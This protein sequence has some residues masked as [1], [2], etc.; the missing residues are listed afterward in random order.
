M[1]LLDTITLCCDAI[2]LLNTVALYRCCRA[3]LQVGGT[4]EPCAVHP[5]GRICVCLSMW[6]SVEII[7]A[8][9]PPPSS[10]CESLLSRYLP[11]G[12]VPAAASSPAPAV[13]T[14]CLMIWSPGEIT[15]LRAG[16]ECDGHT[17]GCGVQN[18]RVQ[19]LLVHRAIG[20]SEPLR[21][22]H[23]APLGKGVAAARE[24]RSEEK[25]EIGQLGAQDSIV[26]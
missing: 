25:E 19:E 9:P 23:M 2:L 11:L 22:L 24:Q 6:F 13:L 15:A 21:S 4:N 1:P 14:P 12:L 3:R 18:R 20:V 26:E 16:Q 10:P 7:L 8:C 17:A 5:L